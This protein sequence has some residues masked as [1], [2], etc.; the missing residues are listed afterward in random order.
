[1]LPALAGYAGARALG[2]LLLAWVSGGFGQAFHLLSGRWD[3]VWYARIVAHGYGVTL[4]PPDGRSLSAMAFFPLYPWLE[5]AL[6]GLSGGLLTVP[7]AGLAVSWAASVAAAWGICA[8]GGAVGGRRVGIVLALLWGAY[9]VAVVQ[10]MAYTETLFTALAAWALY[11][12]LWRRWLTAGWLTLAA[13]LTRPSAAAL[14]AAVWVGMLVARRFDRRVAAGAVLAPLGAAAYVVFVAV[15]TGSVFGYFHVQAEWGNGFDAGVSFA[16]FAWAHARVNAW[17]GVG[18]VAAVAVVAWLLVLCV[19]RR[20]RLPVELIV[21][22]AVLAVMTFGASGFF[23]S[24]PRLLM[25]AF[26]LLLPI[27]FG[28][29]R[30]R[31]RWAVLLLGAVVVGSGVYGAF[32]LQGSGPP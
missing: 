5:Q 22:A 17:A 23:G 24:K 31:T 3:A 29:A 30:W 16:R 4:H 14:V 6:H 7:A 32:M 19:R 2:V 11:A 18:L 20:P 9:P 12:A 1:M 25:P 21:Y 26:P 13:G 15:R 28:V 8:V 27:A 10:S